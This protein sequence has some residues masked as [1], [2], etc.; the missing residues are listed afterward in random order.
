[1]AA[2]RGIHSGAGHVSRLAPADHAFPNSE[3][4]AAPAAPRW[5]NTTVLAGDVGREVSK[6]KREFDGDIVVY[7]SGQLVRTL[8]EHDLVDQ[9]RLT[10]YPFAL[11]AGARLFGEMSDKNASV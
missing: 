10:V 9:L 2:C 1:M 5:S 8:M 7:A 11:G 3:R 6:L 4:A